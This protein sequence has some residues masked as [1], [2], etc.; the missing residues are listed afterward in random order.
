MFIAQRNGYRI[1]IPSASS[2]VPFK[3]C[4]YPYTFFVHNPSLGWCSKVN[5]AFYV[6]DPHLTVVVGTFESESTGSTLPRIVGVDENVHVGSQQLALF[7][8]HMLLLKH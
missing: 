6:V 4:F 7:T 1:M 5:S 8:F 2:S 3:L